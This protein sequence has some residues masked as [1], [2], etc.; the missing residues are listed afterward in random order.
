MK[1]ICTA[2][3]LL[4]GLN[5]TADN[6]SHNSSLS[7]R[8]TDRVS[9]EAIIGAIIYIPEFK[10]GTSTDTLGRY[11]FER[12]PPVTVLIEVSYVGYKT[13]IEKV[14]L[15]VVTRKDFMLEPNIAELNTIV[16]TGS[17]DAVELRRNPIPVVA[18]NRKELE[19]KSYSN[20]IDAIADIPGLN[21]VSTGP[22]ISKPFIHGLGYNRVLT[23][24]DGVR[25][26]G[27]QWGDEH[28][29]EID[30]NDIDRIEVVK[31]PASLMYGSDAIAGV[32]N[33][34]PAPAIQEGKISGNINTVYQANNRLI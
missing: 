23:L 26:E 32:V 17:S 1:F 20:I 25:Q 13:A 3:L 16:V 14:D 34:L 10:I 15:S 30:D 21:A 27:Q 24:Y 29:I 33:L 9:H 19:Q 6:L 28:G 18:I 4:Y 12:L 7:G 5:A 11:T 2:F 22:N 8:I 31:G